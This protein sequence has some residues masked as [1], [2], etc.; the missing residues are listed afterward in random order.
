MNTNNNNLESEIKIFQTKLQV[1]TDPKQKQEIQK[2]LMKLQL[3][4]EI[5]DIRN[6]IEQ[7][8]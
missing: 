8:S 7:I 1:E 4:K 2:K 3:E 5:Q 6:R